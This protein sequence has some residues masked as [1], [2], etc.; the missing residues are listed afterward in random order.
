MLHLIRSPVFP[1]CCLPSWVWCFLFGLSPACLGSCLQSWMLV[2]YPWHNPFIPGL[3]ALSWV[4]LF[5]P[6]SACAFPGLLLVSWDAPAT[7]PGCS[8]PALGFPCCL[9]AKTHHP[10]TSAQTCSAVD[11]RI[12]HV[13]CHEL[14]R[15]S[16]LVYLVCSLAISSRS[17]GWIASTSRLKHPHATN[18]FGLKGA[19]SAPVALLGA[20]GK[21]STRLPPGEPVE[22]VP[23]RPHVLRRSGLKNMKI[24]EN[25]EF[26][27]I[28]TNFGEAITL[29]KMKLRT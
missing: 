9:C 3:H 15:K 1:G 2:I 7:S 11:L 6:L 8:L 28:T 12:R 16:S 27:C 26:G 22:Q 24:I 21:P 18:S 10:M 13:G 17:D 19:C 5:I 25:H 23:T 4:P 29:H 20:G 14:L